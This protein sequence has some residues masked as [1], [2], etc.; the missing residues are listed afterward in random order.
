MPRSGAV[1]FKKGV[2]HIVNN[3]ER[4]FY[5]TVSENY[6]EIRERKREQA[7]ETKGETT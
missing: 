5:V 1:Q 3:S 7:I 2:N 4:A 6:R